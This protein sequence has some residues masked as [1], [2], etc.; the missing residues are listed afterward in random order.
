M[1]MFK[2]NIFPFLFP[3]LL[4]VTTTSAL[5]L[6]KTKDDLVDYCDW[7][8]EDDIQV[9][10][11][12]F[13]FLAGNMV[14]YIGGSPSGPLGPTQPYE[15][16]GLTHPFY[17]DLRSRG[18]GISYYEGWGTGN[19]YTGWGFWQETKVAFGTIMTVK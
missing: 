5:I 11:R 13:G 17:H 8:G 10:T 9:K 4:V 16:I 1:M 15:T 19:D 12:P 7:L 3:L 18:T 14:Y 6:K 2:R